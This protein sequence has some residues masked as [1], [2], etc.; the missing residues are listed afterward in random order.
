[1][2]IINKPTSNK[3]SRDGNIPDII[4]CHQTAG[5]KLSSAL[6]WFMNKLSFTSANFL[7]DLDGTI[8][9][10]VPIPDGAWC[11]GNKIKDSESNASNYYKKSLNPI[12]RSRKINANKYTVSIEFV[13][14]GQ[15]NITEAQKVAG[16]WLMKYIRSELKRIYNYDYIADELHLI[17]H[18]QISPVNKAGCPGKLF[19]FKYFLDGLNGKETSEFDDIRIG[20]KVQYNG[21]VYADSFGGGISN[22]GHREGISVVD[23]I[24]E[25]RKAGY[26]VRGK[27]WFEKS[28]LKEIK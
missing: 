13:H 19:P 1:M 4:V 28:S 15:G 14:K 26:L 3:F 7:V 24:V 21:D 27:G 11:N 8:I 18:N 17:G 2:T 9:Q 6:N 23:K 25:N 16:L 20:D 12:V 22:K 5:T 10:C